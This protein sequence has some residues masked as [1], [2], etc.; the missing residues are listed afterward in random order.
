[1]RASHKLTEDGYDVLREQ[2]RAVA[3]TAL[4]TVT[5][6]GRG[7]AIPL[8]DAVRLSG[9]DHQS[10]TR[11]KA[12]ENSPLRRVDWKWSEGT[13]E[14]A[15]RHP[16]RFELAIWYRNTFLCGLALGRPTWSGNKLRLDFVEASPETT[17]LTGLVANI[18]I[19]AAVAY[20]ASIGA[21]QLRLMNPV[22]S[23]VRSHYLNN[24]TG[25]AYDSKGDFC[26]KD[27]I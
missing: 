14:Y 26:Y 24:L 3:T 8:R 9:V 7:Q 25:F 10:K 16:K 17:P 21:A 22:N 2:A 20:A 6:N 27:I 15:W 19:A 13:A 5:L 23:A 1:M 18:T 11:A 4:P 12:W